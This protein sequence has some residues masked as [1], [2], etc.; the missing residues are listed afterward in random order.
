MDSEQ[1]TIPPQPPHALGAMTNSELSRYR[2]ELERALNDRT[3]G[4]AP[5]AGSLRATLEGVMNEENGRE[6]IRNA[7]RTWPV[8]N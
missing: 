4:S 6:Q 7:G 1:P 2:R 3:I 5:I 8:H